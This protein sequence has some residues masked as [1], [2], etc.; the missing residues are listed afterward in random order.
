MR[1]L[2][3]AWIVAQWNKILSCHRSQADCIVY[4]V[5]M[6]DERGPIK[7]GVCISLESRLRAL[8]TANPY[9]LTLLASVHGSEG[10]EQALH[11]L[12]SSD[13]LRGEWFRPTKDLLNLAKHIGILPAEIPSV[14]EMQQRLDAISTQL[15]T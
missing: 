12:F 10:I 8:Q 14:A 1:P 2:G 7:I 13:N 6:K 3:A 5:Q 15:P 9:Q 4:F 11:N